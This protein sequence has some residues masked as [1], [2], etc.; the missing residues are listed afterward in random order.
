[1]NVHRWKFRLLMFC[2]VLI[3]SFIFRY[4]WLNRIACLFFFATLGVFIVAYCRLILKEGSAKDMYGIVFGFFVSLVPQALPGVA[5]PPRSDPSSANIP[6][7]VI[8]AGD[9]HLEL[10]DIK[11]TP[12]NLTLSFTAKTAKDVTFCINPRRS[13]LFDDKN[14]EYSCTGCSIGERGG[15]NTKTVCKELV[16]GA[17]KVRAA[18]TFEHMQGGV[19]EIARVDVGYSTGRYGSSFQLRNIPLQRATDSSLDPRNDKALGLAGVLT[20]DGRTTNYR[21]TVRWIDVPLLE[22]QLKEN[23]AF[24]FERSAPTDK[25]ITLEFELLGTDGA[26]S[27]ITK[28]HDFTKNLVVDVKESELSAL[29]AAYKIRIGGIIYIDGEPATHALTVRLT[30][31]DPRFDNPLPKSLEVEPRSMG[32][33]SFWIK[34]IS[35]Q[36]V[37][38]AIE[39]MGAQ[40]AAKVP[41]SWEGEPLKVELR[42]SDFQTQDAYFINNPSSGAVKLHELPDFQA[43][44]KNQALILGTLMKGTQIEILETKL[45]AQVP[46]LSWYRIRV[47]DGDFAGR[48]GWVSSSSVEKRQG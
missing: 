15:S 26:R 6:I 5:D 47:L 4:W 2:L 40:K 7:R 42:S 18:I 41:I 32:K 22:A 29:P 24:E 38:L 30:D 48:V 44:T 35:K 43:A 25:S 33:F 17:E 28:E 37:F 14:R 16:R 23:G 20:I 10:V 46:V 3:V 13:K 36:G 19:I 12:A 27:W 9:V 21:G 11:S 8:Q 45:D 1:M 31:P 34:G 39:M